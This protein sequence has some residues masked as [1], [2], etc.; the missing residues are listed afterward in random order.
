VQFEADEKHVKILI[1]E[2]GFDSTTKSVAAPCAKEDDEGGDEELEPIQSSKFRALAARCNFL[3][4]D[5]MDIAYAVKRLCCDMSAPRIRSWTKLRRLVKYLVGVPRMVS[6][7]PRT[8]LSENLIIDVFTDSDWAGCKRTRKSTS[9]GI[10]SVS[11]GIVKTWSKT[12]STIAR[13]SGEAEFYAAA[14][15]AVEAIGLKA[16]GQDLGWSFEIRLGVDSSAAKAMASRTGLGKTRHI[17]VQ[18]LWLQQ[19]LRKDW[20][21]IVKIRGDSN[22]SDVLTKPKSFKEIVVLIGDLGYREYYEEVSK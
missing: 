7:F 17:E 12:Q 13:S 6:T 1:A 14:H 21:R 15:G 9:G 22:P 10:L 18:Y 2:F 8:R 4:A 5:R 11:G 20:F 3:A 16:I 19:I